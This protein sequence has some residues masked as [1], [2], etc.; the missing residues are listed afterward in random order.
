MWP[1]LKAEEVSD[2][3]GYGGGSLGVSSGL[4]ASLGSLDAEA[5]SF[6]AAQHVSA[7]VDTKL[8]WLSCRYCYVYVGACVFCMY[9][10]SKIVLFC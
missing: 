8:R 1:A 3:A 10:L 4:P 2:I 6:W 9:Q 7:E 5:L